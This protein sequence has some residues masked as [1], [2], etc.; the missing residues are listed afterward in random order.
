MN[1]G[2]KVSERG[3]LIIEAMKKLGMQINSCFCKSK[4]CDAEISIVEN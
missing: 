1:L 4:K 3:I 2:E